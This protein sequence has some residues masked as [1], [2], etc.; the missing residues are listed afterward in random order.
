MSEPAPSEMRELY[1]RVYQEVYKNMIAAGY[2]ERAAC[3]ATAAA[4]NAVQS[5]LAAR[6]PDREEPRTD[7][8]NAP[9]PCLGWCVFGTGKDAEW[10]MIWRTPWHGRDGS[11]SAHGCPQDV[12]AW[13][14]MPHPLGISEQEAKG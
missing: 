8:E 1:A 3:E 11:W 5:I 7:F 12:R 4:R 14:P 9:S 2:S 6:L 13:L 10:R